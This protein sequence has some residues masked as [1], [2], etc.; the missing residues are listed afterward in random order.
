M[1]RADWFDAV[2]RDLRFAI[3]QLAKRP[4]FTIVALLTLALGIGANTAIF[5]AVNDVLLRPLPTPALDRL[6]FVHDNLP[7]LPLLETMLDPSETLALTTHNDLFASVAGVNSTAAPVLTGYGDPRKPLEPAPWV[8]S[9]TSSVRRR[10]SAGSIAPTNR[11]TASTASSFCRMISG[12]SLAAN[13]RS[14]GR[15]SC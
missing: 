5:S 8:V 6:V 12:K 13:A 10:R 1:R 3:R 15:R 7:K 4:T 9:S 2:V 14:W 11:R